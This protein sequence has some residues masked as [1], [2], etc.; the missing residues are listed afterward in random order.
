MRT[1][2]ATALLICGFAPGVRADQALPFENGRWTLSGDAK[3]ET[4]LGRTALTA[5]RGAAVAE[6]VS[7]Q[8]GTVELDMAVGT[9]RNFS[10]VYLRRAGEGEYEEFYF[11]THKS[12][13]PDAIQ[14]C[15]AWQGVGGWQL[16]HGPGYT[17]RAAFARD[18]W[19]PIRIVLSGSRAAIF[20]GNAAEPQLVVHRLGRETRAGGIGLEALL[21]NEDFPQARTAFSNVVLKPGV[22]PYDFSKAPV[23]D[24]EAPAGLVKRWEISAPFVPAAGAIPSVPDAK[25]WQTVSAEPNGLVVFE[26]YVKRSD[27]VERP[28]VLARI[29][30][31]SPVDGVRRF[32]IGYSDEV[33]VFLDG[34]PI[35]SG[36]A[37]Y[38]HD[39]PRQE[40]L[41][42]LFQGTV[43]LPLKKGRNELV[44]AIADVFGGWGVMGQFADPEGLRV[45][46]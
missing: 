32:R 4:Y 11:R 8:D 23:R 45:T 43:Y 44:L 30:V 18:Q 6:G 37:H 26:R 9:H 31:E 22:V 13:L 39:N 1:T 38:S 25:G 2:L 40:G 41:I 33:T 3:I 15:P 42:G 24:R 17:A 27:D 34:R 36:D 5:R 20:V 16:F 7:F 29:V 12:E 14:Y 21:L 46:P 10:M 28:A 19:I 35:F